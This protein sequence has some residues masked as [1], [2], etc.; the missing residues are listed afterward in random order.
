M[1]WQF[2]MSL[3]R[4]TFMNL[5]KSLDENLLLGEKILRYWN[6]MNRV[7]RRWKPLWLLLSWAWLINGLKRNLIHGPTGVYHLL[8]HRVLS[9][10]TNKSFNF[11][12]LRVPTWT[13]FHGEPRGYE[14]DISQAVKIIQLLGACGSKIDL[15][16]L[17]YWWV[18]KGILRKV[19]ADKC[20]VNWQTDLLLNYKINRFTSF[21]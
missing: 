3:D 16:S 13:G 14:T 19:S 2:P 8:A 7:Q 5:N 9:A 10:Y 20:F 21:F 11:M 12:D 1:F 15:L 17:D 6:A 4:W 18:N